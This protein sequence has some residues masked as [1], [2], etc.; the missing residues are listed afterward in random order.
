ME[1][2][3]E[4]HAVVTFWLPGVSPGKPELDG[5]YGEH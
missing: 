5:V 1:V 2:N 3:F 4:I